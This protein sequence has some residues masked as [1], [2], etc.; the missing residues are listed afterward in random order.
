M[1]APRGFRLVVIAGKDANRAV[2]VTD[3]TQLPIKI[4]RR[5]SDP[6]RDIEAIGRPATPD[7]DLILDGDAQISR[8]HAKIEAGTDGFVLTDCDSVNR[9]RQNGRLLRPWDPVPLRSGDELRLGPDTLIRFE[10][11]A[12]IPAEPPPPP[13]TPP[14]EPVVLVDRVD[15]PPHRGKTPTSSRERAETWGRFVLSA[16]LSQAAGVRV[17]LALDR[18]RNEQVVL[19]RFSRDQ[20]SN[21]ARNTLLGCAQKGRGWKHASIAEVVDHGERDESVF[22]ASRWIDGK[23]LHDLQLA[24]ARDI[25]I[26]LALHLTRDICAALRHGQVEQ[27]GFVWNE[28]NPHNVIVDRGGHAVLI[29]FGLPS[30]R[31]LFD[32]APAPNPA[33]AR[34][35]SPEQRYGR[36][37]DMR[38]DIYAAG[39]IL[40]EL[41]GRKPVDA[42]QQVLKDAAGLREDIPWD[43]SDA[44]NKAVAYLSERRFIHAADMEDALAALLQKLSPGYAAEASAWIADRLLAS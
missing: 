26:P 20:L 3:A 29:N 5:S 8:L 4:G 6:A 25:D 10:H 38:S 14:P 36:E 9:T 37:T 22:V 35:L 44:V 28:L 13:P 7:R 11:A 40:Y 34:Y 18:E 21:K 17:H 41:L 43:V 32:N 27:R 39:V 2:E 31:L 42:S 19:K 33:D 16:P 1:A 12:E 15:T 23:S 24:Y 30:T